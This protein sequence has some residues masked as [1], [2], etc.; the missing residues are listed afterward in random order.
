MLDLTWDGNKTW[1]SM[2]H[3]FCDGQGISAFLETVLYYYYCL[4]DGKTYEPNGIRTDASPM[5]EGEFQE[6][7]S[8]PYAI[9]PGFTMP[10]KKEQPA[11]YHLPE[12]SPT[13]DTSFRVY[14]LRVS[15]GE[16]M[17]FV[18]KNGTSPSVMFSMLMGEA[19]LRVHPEAD[20]PV[21]ANVPVSLRK[22]L[23]CE[24]TFKN[25]SGRII[26]PIHGTPMDAMP[27]AE[28]AAALRGLLKMQM[29]PNIQRITYNYLGNLYRQ[30]MENAMSYAEEIKKQ[31]KVQEAEL[32]HLRVIE[33]LPNKAIGRKMGLTENAVKL[34]W[35]RL[36]EKL[37]PITEKLL[38]QK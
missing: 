19:I 22:M 27:F 2:F 23:G 20:A 14:S 12:F 15:S 35:L 24:E 37:K 6:P 31:L 11:P 21:M 9:D 36:E 7:L 34:R 8:H 25:C 32:F 17:D 18:R 13:R 1:F 3:G 29:N 26:L 10:E 28:R 38:A 4:K 33:R 5:D 30:R 16:M